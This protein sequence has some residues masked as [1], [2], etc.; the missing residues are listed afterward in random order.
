VSTFPIR[1]AV[2][3]I[4]NAVAEPMSFL[5]FGPQTTGMGLFHGAEQL[6]KLGATT[7]VTKSEPESRVSPGLHLLANDN[8]A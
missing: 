2:R 8:V 4:G 1:P 6:I 3:A 5:R 7:N